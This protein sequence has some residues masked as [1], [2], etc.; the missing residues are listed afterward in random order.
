LLPPPAWEVMD[1][2]TVGFEAAFIL[3][4]VRAAWFRTLCGL[5]CVFHVAV[6]LLMRI[7]FVWNIPAYAA[8]VDWDQWLSRA[9]LAGPVDRA[10]Q[11][12]A[13]RG[14]LALGAVS[15]VLCAIY[16][17]WGSPLRL[18]MS[19]LGPEHEALPRT[20]AIGIA[21]FAVVALA[22]SRLLARHFNCS[23]RNV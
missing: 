6:A 9:R 15:G 13:E 19:V 3:L 12:M 8:F 22:L 23:H 2:M 7:T 11:W 4:V 20:I 1:Y 18:L 17:R 10:Q 16:W 5:A 14:D 21:A